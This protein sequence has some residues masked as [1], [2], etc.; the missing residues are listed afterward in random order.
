MFQET[1]QLAL[2]LTVEP[3]K[4][5]K[6]ELLTV[7]GRFALCSKLGSADRVQQELYDVSQLDFVMR[8]VAQMPERDKHHFWISQSTLMPYARNRRISSVMLL[9]AVWVDIDIAHPPKDFPADALPSWHYDKEAE[10]LALALVMQIEDEC[11]ITASQV[12]ATGGGLLLRLNFERGLPSLA[13]PRWSSLQKQLIK[14]V[15]ELRPAS[16]FSNAR[17]W[18]WPVD[19]AACDPARV[20]RLVGTVNPRWGNRCRVVYDSGK[21]YNFDEL[22]DRLLPY[23]QLEVAE[24]RKRKAAGDEYTKN[25]AAAAAAGIRTGSQKIIVKDA[26]SVVQDMIS[27]EAARGLWAGRFEF[28]RAVLT[29]RGQVQDGTLNNHFWPLANAL[30]WSSSTTQLTQDL[31]ALHHQHFASTGWTRAEA[32]R[33][34]ASVMRKLA[35][36]GPYKAKSSTFAQQLDATHDELA[37]FG[38]LLSSTDSKHN[39]NRAVWNLGAMQFEKMEGL[40]FDE[41]V[42]EIRRRQAL[43]GPQ[44]AQTR[45]T[46]HPPEMHEKARQLSASGVSKTAIAIELKVNRNTI[47]GWLKPV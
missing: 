32:M 10:K 36:G 44:S 17:Q 35:A 12:V 40:S 33:S 39:E 47:I 5:Y 31:A 22:A 19:A 46:T 21:S 30:A 24:F 25:R 16:G 11:G 43:A 42:A 13:R 45:K 20:L 1:E 8:Q 14:I 28:G 6:P 41:Y 9:N 18:Q 29:E 38:H 26:V 27:D 2:E 7:P 15:S 3:K 34:A 37:R 23:T 4:L